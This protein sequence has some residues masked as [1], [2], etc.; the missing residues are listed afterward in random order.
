L[1]KR[2]RRRR[3]PGLASGLLAL[4]AAAAPEAARAAPEPPIV[5]FDRF[6]SESNPV[7]HS[8]LRYLTY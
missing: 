8:G 4:L 5:A 1:V 3:R 6:V 7:C 2:A